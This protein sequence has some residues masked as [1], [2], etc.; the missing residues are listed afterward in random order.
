MAE[1]DLARGQGPLRR[2]APTK[3]ILSGIVVAAIVLVSWMG[4]SAAHEGS[5]LPTGTGNAGPAYVNLSIG[6]DSQ[7]ALSPYR[8]VPANFSVPAHHLLIFVITSHDGSYHRGPCCYND[9]GVT[10]VLGDEEYLNG[11]SSGVSAIR[12]SHIAH[13]FTSFDV[14]YGLNVP[15]P[16]ASGSVP[17]MVQFSLYLNKTGQFTWMCVTFCPTM[18][19]SGFMTGTITVS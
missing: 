3:A 15:I 18:M 5:P 12:A 2:S 10:G 6:H 8:Y 17:T 11:S 4:W 7:D 1:E 19:E 16:V 9:S 13:T 14:P